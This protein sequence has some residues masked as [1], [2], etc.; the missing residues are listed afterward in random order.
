MGS[1]LEDE[2]HH[3]IFCKNASRSLEYIFFFFAL[4][5]RVTCS[6]KFTLLLIFS[7][8]DGKFE[9]ISSHLKQKSWHRF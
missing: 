1:P 4:R 2:L 8:Q 9:L 6:F 3:A 7:M 5:L